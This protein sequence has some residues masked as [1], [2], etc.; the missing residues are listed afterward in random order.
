MTAGKRVMDVV[1]AIALLAGTAPLSVLSGLSIVVSSGMPIVFSQERIGRD[2][3][4]FTLYKFRTM[5]H[6][7]GSASTSNNGDRLSVTSRGDSRITPIGVVLRATKL[8]ELPQLFNVLK[9][10]MS[11]VGPR[12]EVREY[13]ELWPDDLRERVLSVRPGITGLAA[14]TYRHEERLLARATNIEEYYVEVLIPQKLRL[15]DWY[16][17]NAS[18][19]LDLRILVRTTLRIARP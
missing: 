1:G 13:V 18:L 7:S 6:G 8:D 15:D 9:G 5:T 3:K 10:D 16:V 14:I 12:P 4:P 19:L 2:G 11:L 17:R